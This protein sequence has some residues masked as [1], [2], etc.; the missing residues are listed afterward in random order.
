MRPVCNLCAPR[1]NCLSQTLTC[2]GIWGIIMRW[3]ERLVVN[4]ARRTARE[5]IPASLFRRW[6]TVEGLM[7]DE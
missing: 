1:N 3:P 4:V 5:W 6:L 7:D 2:E